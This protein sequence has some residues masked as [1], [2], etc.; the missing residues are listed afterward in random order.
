[1]SGAVRMQVNSTEKSELLDDSGLATQVPHNGDRLGV[2]QS[3]GA[4]VVNCKHGRY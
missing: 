1:M 2:N 4:C 3:Y